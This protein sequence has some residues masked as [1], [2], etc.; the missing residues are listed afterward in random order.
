MNIFQSVKCLLNYKLTWK[1]SF[2]KSE[3]WVWY[4]FSR[5]GYLFITMK[6]LNFHLGGKK[7]I[8]REWKTFFF[9]KSS[10]TRFPCNRYLYLLV[11]WVEHKNLTVGLNICHMSYAIK[12]KWE[13]I[14]EIMWLKNLKIELLWFYLEY[15][16]LKY[17]LIYQGCHQNIL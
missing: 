4:I 6:L 7:T 1:V 3:N 12:H 5:Y 8:M 13:I 16:H 10:I 9:L 17:L 14:N 11:V 15:F 2:I